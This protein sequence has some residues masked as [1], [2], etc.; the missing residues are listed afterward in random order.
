MYFVLCFGCPLVGEQ[1]LVYVF[2]NVFNF[3]IFESPKNR[4]CVVYGG[5]GGGGM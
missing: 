3:L 4:K 5:G 1:E 2:G